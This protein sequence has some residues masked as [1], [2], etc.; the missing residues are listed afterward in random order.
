MSLNILQRLQRMIGCIEESQVQVH[1]TTF[2][3]TEKRKGNM[4][5]SQKECSWSAEIQTCFD[6]SYIVCLL[7]ALRMLREACLKA[8][9]QNRMV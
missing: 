3:V 6:H 8:L 1:R 7:P 4:L 9:Q 2:K 5:P